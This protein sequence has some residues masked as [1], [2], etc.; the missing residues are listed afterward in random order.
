MIR[1]RGWWLQVTGTGR[2]GT[3]YL[4]KVLTSVGVRCTHEGI[5]RPHKNPNE[6]GIVP[7]G[8]ATE[9]D[10]KYRLNMRQQHPWWNW[11]AD[12][13][14]LAAPF[15][16]WESM[17][18]LVVVHLVRNPQDTL[19]SM[20]R[21]GG[22]GNEAPGGLYY[23]FAVKHLPQVLH[24]PT[25]EEQVAYLYVKWNEMIEPHATLRWRVEDDVTTLLDVLAIDWRDKDL[26]CDVT[27]N[28][29]VGYREGDVDMTALPE[30]LQLRLRKVSE[31][32]GY[33]WP[34]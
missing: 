4:S 28:T 8:L 24:F 5:F 21:L 32:Y 26:F 33:E 34:G 9:D 29:R 25:V 27:Y 20:A 18:E 10:I 1:R 6:N 23:Q 11:N 31:R 13:S 2:C 7:A 14:W 19:N 15:L 3:G 17:Q 30:D 16:G 22:I 12:S